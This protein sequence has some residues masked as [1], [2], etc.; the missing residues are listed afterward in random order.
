MYLQFNS[1]KP[2]PARTN[3]ARTQ[4]LSRT[5][6]NPKV[7]NMQEPE[8]NLPRKEPSRTRTL[9]SWF[10]L[11]PTEPYGY[12]YSYYWQCVQNNLVSPRGLELTLLGFYIRG[13]GQRLKKDG[14]TVP[15][16]PP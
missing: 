8:P 2:E 3:R 4:V 5:E 13:P 11:G 9:M 12:A 10:L 7:K 15:S 14:N 1:V 16:P 6:W